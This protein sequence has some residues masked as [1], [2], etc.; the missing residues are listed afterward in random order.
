M[1]FFAQSM[2]GI[3]LE[4]TRHDPVYEDMVLKFTEHFLFIGAAMDR[5]GDVDDELWDDEDGFF[6]DVLRFPD[7]GAQRLKVRSL[8]GLLPIAACTM[9]DVGEQRINRDLLAQIGRRI[10]SMPELLANIHDPRQP[11]VHDRRLLGVL[12]DVKLRKVLARMLD[13]DEFLSPYGI[14]SL[15][16]HHLE[17]PFRMEVHGTTYEV[18]YLPAESDSG[19]FGGNSNWRGPVWMPVNFLILRK[20]LGLYSYY[21]DD[22]TVECPT[23]SGN[24]CTLFEVAMEIGRRLVSIFLPDEL[25]HRPVFGGNERFRSDPNWKDLP[26]FYEYFHGDDGAGLGASHQTG[27]TGLVAR[28]IQIMGYLEPADLLDSGLRGNLVYRRPR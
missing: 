1:A 5:I 22:F 12:D 6:Y 2:L 23:G 18:A 24:Q 16:K 10:S 9:F 21:G 26:L 14:R 11:G 19:M 28:I 7:G 25:G 8:V 4:L 20:L 17:H 3:A 13:E 15:S 27:W